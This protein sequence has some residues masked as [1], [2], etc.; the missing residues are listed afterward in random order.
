MIKFNYLNHA[1]SHRFPS[2]KDLNRHIYCEKCLLNAYIA[3][4]N[5]IVSITN[6]EASSG[7]WVA[8]ILTCEEVIIKNILE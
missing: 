5:K 6:Y 1:F 7:K 2:I 8:I 3:N 4:I